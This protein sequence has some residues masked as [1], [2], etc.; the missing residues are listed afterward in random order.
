[1]VSLMLIANLGLLIQHLQK[2]FKN[3]KKKKKKNRHKKKGKKE[4]KGLVS[5]PVFQH[6]YG[7]Y[8]SYYL[9][10]KFQ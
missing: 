9:A 5:V 3:M 8:V 10:S 7:F 1:M 2:R 4:K 6:W